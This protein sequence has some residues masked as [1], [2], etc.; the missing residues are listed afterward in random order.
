M[1]ELTFNDLNSFTRY[2][3]PL[4]CLFLFYFEQVNLKHQTPS[5]IEI[6]SK[7]KHGGKSASKKTWKVTIQGRFWK[8]ARTN[9]VEVNSLCCPCVNTS[10]SGYTNRYGNPTTSTP[11][12]PTA[13]TTTAL[14]ASLIVAGISTQSKPLATHFERRNG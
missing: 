12:P 13:T 4:C 8:S 2:L 5:I 10:L 1:L 11:H 9:L 7:K 3:K 14:K 6:W